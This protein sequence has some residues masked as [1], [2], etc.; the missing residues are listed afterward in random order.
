MQVQNQGKK[1]CRT[2]TVLTAFCILT[3]LLGGCRRIS[4]AP[5]ISGIITETFPVIE[6]YYTIP[7]AGVETRVFSETDSPQSIEMTEKE[8]MV[9]LQ[10]ES[11]VFL[12][13]PPVQTVKE[14][15]TVTAHPETEAPVKETLSQI[16]TADSHKTTAAPV[17]EQ[18]PVSTLIESANSYSSKNSYEARNFA[19]QKGFW[20]TYLEFSGILKNKSS[21]SF[22]K[23]IGEYFDNIKKIGFNTVYV[24][25]RAFGDAYYDSELFPATDNFNGVIGASAKF[26]ALDIMV[27][28][29]HERG[30][31]IH[32]WVNPMRLM[33]D[34][35]LKNLNDNYQ[36]KKWYNNNKYR[37]NY[38]VKSGGRWYLNPAYTEVTDFIADGISEIV[39]GYD[40]DGIQIDDYF[41]PTTSANFDRNAFSSGGKG[42]KLSDWR[43]RNVNGMVKK[44]YSAAHK[45][46]SSIMFGISPQGSIENNYKELY[47]DVR[48]WCSE[49][50]YCDYI[51]PQ[52]YFGFDNSSL[53]Y[54]KVISDWEK[55][56]TSEN[57]R[58]VIGLAGYKIGAA[59]S[60][61]GGSARNEWIN[62]SDI[63][64]RQMN[65]AAGLDKYGGVALYRYESIFKPSSS[66]SAQ[67][68]KELNNIKKK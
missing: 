53:P 21:A 40:V 24:Q 43:I 8:T 11:P 28:E 46:N 61:A 64:A 47:A 51:L 16:H 13:T 49:D 58:L 65:A 1:Q 29:A 45:A 59:D 7:S 55:M 41:Y 39:S 42:M 3:S 38:L 20:I 33:T 56:C 30:L 12:E 31:S 37:G 22:K 23:S 10:P 9:T 14:T 5:E 15:R 35:Q 50:G 32:A 54:K 25:V 44:L 36:V 62:K 67:V 18:L 63:I 19:E 57:V 27:E 68:S 26:D 52:V 6:E 17:T 66:V 4:E 48:K 2:F 60:Y 34:T